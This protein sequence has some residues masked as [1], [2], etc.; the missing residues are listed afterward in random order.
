MLVLLPFML[1]PVIIN[2][3]WS[4]MTLNVI[5]IWASIFSALNFVRF[6][7]HGKDIPQ[8]DKAYVYVCNHS[9]Y[10]DGVALPLAIPGEFKPLGKKELL[11]IPVFGWILK[12]IAVLV[13]RSSV[14]SRRESVERLARSFK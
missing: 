8:K 4:W 11:K 10:L 2:P 14:E 6:N 1:L 3:V 5:R 9:S 12:S 7:I 13:D